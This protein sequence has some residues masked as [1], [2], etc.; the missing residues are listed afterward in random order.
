ME[1][2][3]SHGYVVVAD[4]WLRDHDAHLLDGPSAQYP[5]ITFFYSQP[6][7]GDTEIC[8]VR[9]SLASTGTHLNDDI[10]FV[11]SHSLNFV[12]SI[13]QG[14]RNAGVAPSPARLIAE[15]LEQCGQPHVR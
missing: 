8:A 4:R 1:D 7:R 13:S 5:E 9:H 10:R 15:K 14:D 2:L 12:C 11:Q 3:A 6:T